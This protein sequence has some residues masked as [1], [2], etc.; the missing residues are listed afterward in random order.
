MRGG[1]IVVFTHAQQQF[2]THRLRQHQMTHP[3]AASPQTEFVG[4]DGHHHLPEFLYLVI[5]IVR[6]VFALESVE[7]LVVEIEVIGRFW[8]PF[9]AYGMQSAAYARV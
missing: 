3:Y 1:R 8:Q 9:L 2:V 6:W 5:C 7:F 4:R